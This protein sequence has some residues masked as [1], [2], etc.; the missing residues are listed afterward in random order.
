MDWT[1]LINVI[2]SS[3]VII[4]VV[5]LV[6]YR[7]E[8]K[9][10][11]GAEATTAAT[12]AQSEQ[13]DLG[14]KFIDQSL[15]VLEQVKTMQQEASGTQKTMLEKLNKLDERMDKLE[16]QTFNIEQYLNG[17]YHNWLAKREKKEQED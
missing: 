16:L 3:G 11:K 14:K 1:S 4:S 17:D 15:S 6:R 9:R 10:I 2:I 8:S 13:I 7:K 5:E 12:Q